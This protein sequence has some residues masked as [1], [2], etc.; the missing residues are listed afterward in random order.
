M[1][2]AGVVRGCVW[3]GGLSR[4]K[5]QGPGQRE[6]GQV[7]PCLLLPLQ[8]VGASLRVRA[9][10]CS[11]TMQKD[12]MEFTSQLKAYSQGDRTQL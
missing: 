7:P 4:K 10:A 12:C 3:Y 2:P 5:G 8:G 11:G 9:V 6:E 1:L